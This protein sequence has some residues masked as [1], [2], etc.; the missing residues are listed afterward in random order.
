VQNDRRNHFARALRDEREEAQMSQEVLAEKMAVTRQRI[1]QW[2]S[3]E[4][5]DPDTAMSL[6]AALGVPPGRLTHHLGYVPAGDPE[7]DVVRTIEADPK[8]EQRFHDM[9]IN[10]YRE[11]V[12][13]SDADRRATR[14]AA[15]AKSRKRSSK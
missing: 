10:I 9:V 15:P 3:G 12:E 1:S 4:P 8:L 14:L 5:I 7:P 11:A 13:L 6:E 2:E